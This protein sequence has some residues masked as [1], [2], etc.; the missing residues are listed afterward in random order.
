AKINVYGNYAF[1]YDHTIQTGDNFTQLTKGSD[2]VT[3]TS[4][5]DRNAKRQ[6]HNARVGIDFQVDSA[7]VIGAV[8]G[9]YNNYW[10]MTANNGAVV[11]INNQTDTTI[12]TINKEVNRWQNLMGN[13]NMQH[14]F[15][16]G[17]TL[18][19]DANYIYYKDNNPNTY[20][21]TYYD[22]VSTLLY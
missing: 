10:T 12:N 22:K 4:F 8:V 20:T 21:N 14:T 2:V 15:E 11:Q 7:T 13:I 1:T 9:G 6:V 3:N 18:S 19:F 16:P 5:S 17:K